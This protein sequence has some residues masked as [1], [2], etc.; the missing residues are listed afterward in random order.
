MK[1]LELEE[2]IEEI[3]VGSSLQPA[4]KRKK[5]SSSH[6]GLM[7]LSSPDSDPNDS[8]PID[9]IIEMD[10]GGPSCNTCHLYVFNIAI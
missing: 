3:T 7:G 5:K 1:F 6:D 2:S 9:Q 4:A 8:I 10:F